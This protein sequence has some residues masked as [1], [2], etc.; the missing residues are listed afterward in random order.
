MLHERI[1]RYR[2][3]VWLLN[4]GTTGGPYGV[5]KRISLPYTRALVRA[6]LDGSLERVPFEED[7]H[8]GLRFPAYCPGLSALVTKATWKDPHAYRAKAQELVQLFHE[9]LKKYSGGSV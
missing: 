9:Q 5:G 6:A 3:K 4:T 7:P 2:A 1:A 8:F